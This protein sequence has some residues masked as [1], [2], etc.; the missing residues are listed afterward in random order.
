MKCF[1]GIFYWAQTSHLWRVTNG[2]PDV[3]RKTTLAHTLHSISSVLCYRVYFYHITS[4]LCMD[5][6]V[7]K[8]LRHSVLLLFSHLIFFGCQGIEMHFHRSLWMKI[9][10]VSLFG[11]KRFVLILMFTNDMVHTLKSM[12]MFTLKWIT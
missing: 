4:S 5:K 6:N 1:I 9:R 7:C 11:N 3:L 12:I 8:Q 10:V 2:S